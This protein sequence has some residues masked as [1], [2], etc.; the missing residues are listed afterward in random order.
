MV[1]EIIPKVDIVLFWQ[2]WQAVVAAM[3]DDKL[4]QS[5]SKLTHLLLAYLYYYTLFLSRVVNY[6]FTHL[7]FTHLQNIITSGSWKIWTIS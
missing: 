2:I 1:N 4:N 5:I 7:A 6:L 3:S